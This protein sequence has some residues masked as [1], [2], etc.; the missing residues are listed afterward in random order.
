MHCFFC[1]GLSY[2]PAVEQTFQGM[3][4]NNDPNILLL[5]ETK[6]HHHMGKVH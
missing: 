4:L 6:Q 2:V 1:F 5:V 3:Q